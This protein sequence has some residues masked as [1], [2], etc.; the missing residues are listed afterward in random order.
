MDTFETRARQTPERTRKKQPM[1]A[2]TEPLKGKEISFWKTSLRRSWTW[3]ISLIGHA[4]R[5]CVKRTRAF[6][7]PT[8]R[9]LLSNYLLSVKK[10]ADISPLWICETFFRTIFEIV[11]AWARLTLRILMVTRSGPCKS[12]V[13]FQLANLVPVLMSE[14]PND[15]H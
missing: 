13:C 10:N 6:A 7:T 11:K 2:A 14:R 12:L 8:W 3:R 5:N 15:V 1:M 9:K 4:G